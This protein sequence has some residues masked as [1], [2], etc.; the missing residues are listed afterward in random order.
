MRTEYRQHLINE[1]RYA[2]TKM[3]GTQ[4]ALKK[5]FY[6]S[7]LFGEA[8]RILNWEWDT[9]LALIYMVTHQVHAQINATVQTPGLLQTLPIDWDI[10]LNKLTQASSDLAD[11]FERAE[12]GGNKEELQRILGSLAGIWFAVTGNGSYLWDKGSFK[13]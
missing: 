2:V 6:F 1:Y 9:E 10:I 12:N 4:E 8:Q 3:Q 5:V 11:Y 7:A 13:L